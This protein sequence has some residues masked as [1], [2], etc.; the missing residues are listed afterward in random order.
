MGTQNSTLQNPCFRVDLGGE[1][2]VDV[3]LYD[4]ANQ[5][6][7]EPTCHF[8]G[9]VQLKYF[10]LESIVS[11]IIKSFF[12]VKKSSCYMFSSVKAFHDG[13]G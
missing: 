5:K 4:T 12:D 1:E 3:D 2:T 10:I 13:L 6:V 7:R 11:N 8:G 9:K